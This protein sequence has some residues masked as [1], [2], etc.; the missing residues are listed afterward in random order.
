MRDVC[1]KGIIGERSRCGF[2]LIE[3]LVVI[4]IIAILAAMLLPALSKAKDKAKRTQWYSNLK[5]WGVC[6]FLYAGDN[7]D[8][9][10]TGWADPTGDGMW[11]VALKQYYSADNIRYCPAAMKTRDT[12]VNFWDTTQ[13]ARTWAWGVMGSNGYPVIAPWGRPGLGGSYGENGW[14]HNLPG[15]G[16]GYWR[17]LS[18]AGKFAD[19]PLFADCLWDGSEPHE[20]DTPPPGPGLQVTGGMGNMSNFSLPRHSIRRPAARA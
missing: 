17:K 2:T 9:M 19:A 11:M 12:M 20:T 8:S 18:K 14:M 7:N 6:F 1:H 5:Q 3:L 10:T 4:A 15:T 13:D 16:N